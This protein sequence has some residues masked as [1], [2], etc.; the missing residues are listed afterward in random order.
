MMLSMDELGPPLRPQDLRSG[1]GGRGYDAADRSGVWALLTGYWAFGQY[2]GVW[3]ILVFEV[4]ALHGLTDSRLGVS[5]ALLSITAVTVMLLVAPRMRGLPLRTSITL[6]LTTLGAASLAVAFLPSGLLWIGFVL[7]G[8]GNGLVDVYFNVAAQR[9]EVHTGRPVLQ[10]MHAA[11]ALGGVT[12]AAA[13][14]L[15]RAAGIDFRWGF[16]YET[17]VLLVVTAWNARIAPRERSPAADT[18]FSVSELLRHPALWIAALAVLFAFLVEGSMDAWSGLYLR[19]QLGASA[20]VAA[21][22]FVG[23]SGAVFLGRLFAG[24]VLFGLGVRTTILVSGFGAT[25]AGALVIATDRPWVVGGAYLLL[26]FTISSAAP[27]GFGLIDRTDADPTNAVA[28]VTTV[29]YTGFVWS[30]P[31]LGYLAQT[32]SLRAAMAVILVAT[33]GIVGAGLAAPRDPGGG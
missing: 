25:V 11:Y 29:G 15:I 30:P 32:I 4:Q 16:V 8:I 18:I 2:W 6:A 1:P 33:V 28:A 5:Y 3:V 24:R 9:A 19:E 31:L 14:G 12:G 23:F 17:L 26:G 21:I 13:A 22:A 27:A 7:V 20:A 10:W